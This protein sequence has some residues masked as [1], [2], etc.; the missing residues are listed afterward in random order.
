MVLWKIAHH[1]DYKLSKETAR[2][3]LSEGP[4]AVSYYTN[5]INTRSVVHSHSYHEIVYNVSGSNVL[6]SADGNK[7][8]L[9][10]GDVIFFPMEHFHNGIYNV[11]ENHS[12]RLVVQIDPD[13][14]NISKKRSHITW[15]GQVLLIGTGTA[16]KWD[17]RG[18]FERMAQTSY[19]DKDSQLMIY[20]SQILELQ[21]LINQFV[22]ENKINVFTAKNDIVKR[23]IDYLQQ[24]YTNPMFSV[25]ELADN[26]CISRAH[27]SRVFKTYTLESV[28]EYLTELRMHKCRQ[29]IADGNGILDSSIES[30]FSDYTSFVKAFKKLYNMTPQEFR[31]M[32]LR[33]IKRSSN[34][35]SS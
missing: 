15:D 21:L 28:H 12:V 3:S 27:L 16:V 10:K 7:Y 1:Y 31:R 9:Q 20:E 23:A 4:V 13:V 5:K 18:L 26:V 29:M 35:F 33:E 24:N 25:E 22:N 6:Y 8:T 2:V 19:V 11:T 30:G 17:L 34:M 32:L 14:W